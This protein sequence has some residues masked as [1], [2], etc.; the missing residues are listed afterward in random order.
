MESSK[1]AF[2]HPKGGGASALPAVSLLAG[3]AR[4]ILAALDSARLSLIK[5][6]KPLQFGVNDGVMRRLRQLG[7]LCRALA[8]LSGSLIH[9]VEEGRS[10][11]TVPS[12]IR[13][14]FVLKGLFYFLRR[15]T[16]VLGRADPERLKYRCL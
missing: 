8:H 7:K 9:E 15:S 2:S 5:Q 1:R 11:A 3:I 6:G 16:Y 4:L 10:S 12:Q 14:P 13:K